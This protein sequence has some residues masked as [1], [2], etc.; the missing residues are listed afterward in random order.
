MHRYQPWQAGSPVDCYGPNDDH[1]RRTWI[2]LR[3]LRSI[4]ATSAGWLLVLAS[5]CQEHLLLIG[6]P[7]TAKTE[8]VNRY[9]ELV[10]ARRF[11]Y[12]LTRFTEPSE[13]FGPLDLQ[14]FQQGAFHIRTEGM[15]PEVQIAFLDEVFQ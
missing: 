4:Q 8:L 2:A 5:I 10:D 12:L 13:L 7:G 1:G 14:A 6:P 11:H 15:L 9:A 3:K